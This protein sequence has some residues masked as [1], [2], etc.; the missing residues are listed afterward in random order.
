MSSDLKVAIEALAD[1]AGRNGLIVDA[2][3]DL[4]DESCAAQRHTSEL[5][6]TIYRI[7]QEALTNAVKNGHATRGVVEVIE[8]ETTVEVSIRDDGA[9][10]DP[11]NR[12]EGFGV[13]GMRERAALLHGTI[14][15]DSAPG[16]GTRAPGTLPSNVEPSPATPQLPPQTQ[17]AG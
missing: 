3:I 8:N 16:R 13:L 17:P 5:E 12:T 14:E 1:R 9:G 4:A 10:F 11:A 7:V 2:A 15:I 6:T